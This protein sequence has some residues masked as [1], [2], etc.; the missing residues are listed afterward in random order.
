MLRELDEQR[1][2]MQRGGSWRGPEKLGRTAVAE[3]AAVWKD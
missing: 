3:L 2:V 1:V